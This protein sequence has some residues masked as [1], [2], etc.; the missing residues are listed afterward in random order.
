VSVKAKL[1][2]PLNDA[3]RPLHVQLV[4]GTSPDPA[5]RDFIPARKTIAAAEKAGLSVSDYIDRTFAEPGTTPDTVK[6]MLELADLHGKCETVCEIGP[7]SG[8]YAEEVIAALHPDTYEI[9]ET[10]K[11]WLPHLAK[12]PNAKILDCDGRTLSQTPSASV[13]LVHSQKTFVY[14]EFYVTA[15]YLD[16][17]ARV[18]RPGGAIAF[19]LVTEDCLNDKVIQ[20][21]TERGSIYR[22]V[23]RAWTIDYL[24]KRGLTLSGSYFAPLPPPPGSTELLVFRRD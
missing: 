4:P 15:G 20:V 21:W 9:Y 2:K 14:L 16:E 13:D 10:A 1:A 23:S 11:D 18:V 7:G 3:L 8:R 6:A 17:M 22:P 19:D 24:Q 12:L 5:I